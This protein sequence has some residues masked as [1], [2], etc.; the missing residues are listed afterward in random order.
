LYHDIIQHYTNNQVYF[1]HTWVKW[2]ARHHS[3]SIGLLKSIL[4]IRKK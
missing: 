4:V 2:K 1:D 3:S